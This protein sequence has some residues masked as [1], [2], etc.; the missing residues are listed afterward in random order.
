MKKLWIPLWI[1]LF[2]V[3]YLFCPQVHF[4][5]T[6]SGTSIIDETHFVDDV[7]NLIEIDATA[8]RIISLFDEHTE[9][10]F[11]LNA[12]DQIIGVSSDSIYPIDAAYLPRYDCSVDYD[13]Q[14]II[15]EQPDLVLIAPEINSQYPSFITKLETAGLKVVSLRP[16]SFDEFDAYI[17]KLG[18]LIG[19]NQESKQYLLRLHGFLEQIEAQS[20]LAL[21][22]AGVFIEASENGYQTSARGSLPYLAVQFAGAKNIAEKWLS[23]QSTDEKVP[24]GKKRILENAENIDVYITIQG[25]RSAGS[26][27]ISINQ[28]P[29]FVLLPAIK[30]GYAYEFQSSLINSYTMRY[31]K[32]VQEIARF[33]Y[34]E[35][36]DGLDAYQNDNILC[37]GTF[38]D[39]VCRYYHIPMFVNSNMD[40]YKYER[41]NHLYGSFTDVTWQNDSFDAVETVVMRSY[42]KAKKDELGNDYFDMNA[43]VTREEIAQFI[44]IICDIHDTEEH[45]LIADIEECEQKRIIQRV[46]DRGLMQLDKDLFHPGARIT[47]AQFIDLLDHIPAQIK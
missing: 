30:S 13:T 10:L 8:L 40:Y 9:N 45:V 12:E 33:C 3:V 16:D 14:R 5:G 28:K 47:N 1:T 15:A 4:G 32:A 36:F 20:A 11:T 6:A 17:I 42:L 22:Q 21:K 27:L 2:A 29:E 31:V 38:V 24:F 18:M 7:G 46:I 26:S 41:F 39:I 43:P 35:I 34:P 25:G 44:N 19:K 23:S 37:R